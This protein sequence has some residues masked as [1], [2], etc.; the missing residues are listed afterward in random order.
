NGAAFIFFGHLFG[1]QNSGPNISYYGATDYSQF[2]ACVASAG[3]IDGD[4]FSEVIIGAPY[5]D[6]TYTDQGKAYVYSYW[7]INPYILTDP[8]PQADA[9]FGNS[10]A[11]A[12]DVN[13]N[14]F[15][16]VVVGEQSYD[17]NISGV[18][19]PDAGR[20]LVFNGWS[21]GLSLTP[22]QVLEGDEDNA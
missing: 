20:A 14:G 10:V 13:A 8:P 18:V 21:T 19:H 12:G 1:L 22:A 11:S 3:D 7:L 9:H 4:G 5:D 15:S 2:G 16:D 17:T 6:G